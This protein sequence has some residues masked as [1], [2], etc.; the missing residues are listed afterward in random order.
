MGDPVIVVLSCPPHGH[1]L[2]LRDPRANVWCSSGRYANE[3]HPLVKKKGD[4]QL[5][6]ILFCCHVVSRPS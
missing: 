3:P 1:C 2:D 6:R 5:L 4:C